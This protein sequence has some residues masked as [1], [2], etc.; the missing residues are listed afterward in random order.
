VACKPTAE[1]PADKADAAPKKGEAEA[2]AKA[3]IPE[4]LDLVILN[5][6]VM[7]PETKLDAIRNVGVKDGKIVAITEQAIKGKESIDAKGHVVAPGFIDP[8]VHAIELSGFSAKVMLRGGVTTQLEL[9]VGAWPVDE[10]YAQ[11]EGKWQA[12]YGASVGHLPIRVQVLDGVDPQGSNVFTDKGLFP[13]I[14]KSGGK[15]ESEYEGRDQQDQIIKMVETGLKQGGL[16][17]GF[18]IGY[19]LGGTSSYEG[20][21]LTELSGKYGRFITLHGRFSSQHP[22]TSGVLGTQEV[23]A[24]VAVNGGGFW[25]HHYHAQGLAVTPQMTE[26]IEAGRAKGI[27]VAGAVYPYNFGSTIAAA[28]YLVPSN[29]GP[30]MGRTYKDLI[31]VPAM[32]PLTKERY[33]YLVKNEPGHTVLFYHCTEKTLAEVVV[34]PGVA[35]ESDAMPYLGDDGNTLPWDAPYESAKGHPRAAGTHAK[36]LRM[37]REKKWDMPLMLALDK[38]SL[39]VARFLEENGVEPMKTKGRLQEG[40]DADIVVFDPDTVTDNSTQAQGA[41]PSTGIP[42]VIVN[43]TIVVKDS[44]VLKGVHPG[45]PVRVPVMD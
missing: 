30:D 22:P 21:R 29:Y 2:P 38:M 26:L 41:L 4:D 24:S 12:N 17:I 5:G 33:E 27:K 3:A 20:F 42:F 28:P 35:I 34:H 23:L 11:R 14:N 45:Q 25:V 6:R 10:F 37:V 9:E 15:Y 7:D 16:G 19:E 40:M 13:G 39:M 1:E 8:H 36:T 44:K 32:K 18:P 31:E 43:G